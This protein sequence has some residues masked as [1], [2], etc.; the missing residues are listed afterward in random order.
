MILSFV[1]PFASAFHAFQDTLLC[2]FPL[3]RLDFF[4]NATNFRHPV[5]ALPSSPRERFQGSEREARPENC[6][7]NRVPAE[8][9]PRDAAKSSFLRSRRVRRVSGITFGRLSLV[10]IALST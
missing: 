2:V 4:R 8:K 5:H 9:I 1:I 3:A 7:E 6:I 10:K